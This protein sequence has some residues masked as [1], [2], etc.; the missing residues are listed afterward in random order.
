MHKPA[1]PRFNNDPE[2]FKLLRAYKILFWFYHDREAWQCLKC[3]VEES[4]VKP[5]YF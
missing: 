3:E 2:L 5:F 1:L 4:S